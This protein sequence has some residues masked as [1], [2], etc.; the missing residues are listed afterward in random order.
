LL[1][2]AGTPAP[3]VARLQAEI[4]QALKLPEVKERLAA[5]GAEPVGSTPAEFATL[6][7]SEIEKWANVARNAN[8][9]PE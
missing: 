5:D 6:I 4:A 2:P 8:I 1:A 3:I 9:Q 7:K